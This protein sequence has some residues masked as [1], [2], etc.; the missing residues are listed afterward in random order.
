MA[1]QVTIPSPAQK[2]WASEMAHE[3]KEFRQKMTTDAAAHVARASSL[4]QTSDADFADDFKDYDAE[5]KKMAAI[6]FSIHNQN[7]A[8]PSSFAEIKAAPKPEFEGLDKVQSSLK[9]LEDKLKSETS[10]FDK[11]AKTTFVEEKAAPSS[12]LERGAKAHTVSKDIDDFRKSMMAKSDAFLEMARKSG[13]NI[14]LTKID[15]NHKHR[16]AHASSLLQSDS[17]KTILQ[18]EMKENPE[19]QQVDEKLANLQSQLH[20]NAQ[21]F[22]REAK[23]N[24]LE[25]KAPAAIPSSFIQTE[26]KPN[27]GESELSAVEKTL[28]DLNSKV[29]KGNAAYKA[30]TESSFIQLSTY[31]ME[32]K[33]Q[34]SDKLH[35]LQQRLEAESASFDDSAAHVKF[36]SSF[37]QSKPSLLQEAPINDAFSDLDK[38]QDNLKGLQ[39]KLDGETAKFDEQA[40][41]ADFGGPPSFIQISATRDDPDEEDNLDDVVTDEQSLSKKLHQEVEKIS[42]SPTPAR[43]STTKMSLAQESDVP[44]VDSVEKQ[45]AL[46]QARMVKE[47]EAYVASHSA[48]PSS[49]LEEEPTL[50]PAMS[51]IITKLNSNGK[52]LDKL[53]DGIYQED[54]EIRHEKLPVFQIPDDIPKKYIP[55]DVLDK[56]TSLLQT[57]PESGSQL[58]K[59][60]KEKIEQESKQFQV[61][62]DSW[63]K[64][65]ASSFAEVD[66]PKLYSDSER[67]MNKIIE[68]YKAQAADSSA[69][70]KDG[71]KEAERTLDQD[72]DRITA[73]SKL[74][75]EPFNKASSL[76]QTRE[77]PDDPAW[78]ARLSDTHATVENDIE[79]LES[80]GKKF[81]A[82]AKREND[83]VTKYKAS[84]IMT[85]VGGKESKFAKQMEAEDAAPSALLQEPETFNEK[86]A[87]QKREMSQKN[88]EMEKEMAAQTKEIADPFTSSLGMKSMEKTQEDAKVVAEMDAMNAVRD[89][90]SDP[91][92]KFADESTLDRR[93]DMGMLGNANNFEAGSLPSVDLVG[94]LTANADQSDVAV[95]DY[96]QD[97]TI[98]SAGGF[99]TPSDDFSQP[100]TSWIQTGAEKEPK[101]AFA[102]L[103]VVQDKLKALTSKLHGESTKFHQDVDPMSLLETGEPAHLPG[104]GW[105]MAEQLRRGY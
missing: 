40:Q 75:E 2:K 14:D 17:G 12:L 11:E 43:Y 33:D 49:L 59:E 4:L 81:G 19:L 55:S 97:D 13:L 86:Y 10:E 67:E 92:M 31:K 5:E 90:D 61:Q 78:A 38:V 95:P 89:L 30:A 82:Q 69:T 7:A 101:N 76:M 68:Q 32:E 58:L 88:D 39:T 65:K 60:L 47:K 56:A 46:I 26:K 93:A 6:D 66:M 52:T 73:D 100:A 54:K 71:L 3:I 104:P 16:D 63:G 98:E 29:A 77:L 83:Y 21:R 23:D 15:T 48:G 37:S 80:I 35:A 72:T 8:T 103:D 70:M 50:S 91:N 20:A 24:I 79:K 36:D 41:A 99:A 44:T 9:A 34:V 94:Q 22:E 18:Q 85:G 96:A 1:V 105:A 62:T 87:R 84:K 45:I 51:D 102:D 64:A 27:W 42:K 25:E 28:R 53:E 74:N 57:S